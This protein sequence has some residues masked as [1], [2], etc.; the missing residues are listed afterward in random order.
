V[1]AR[2]VVSE[3]DANTHRTKSMELL[4]LRQTGT[5]EEYC[6]NFE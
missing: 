5:V 2:A 1:F 3:F 6:R 4:S